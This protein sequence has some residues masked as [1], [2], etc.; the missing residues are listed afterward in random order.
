MEKDVKIVFEHRMNT[1]RKQDLLSLGL[2]SPLG[3]RLRVKRI[4]LGRECRI[5]TT[6]SVTFASS[7]YNF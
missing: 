6:R 7:K 2:A 5:C 3:R 1:L 4:R